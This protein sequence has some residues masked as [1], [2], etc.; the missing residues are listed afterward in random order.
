MV[1]SAAL[2]LG[3]RSTA[4]G[5]QA[6]QR[7]RGSETFGAI[8]RGYREAAGLSQ[9]ALAARSGVSVD[10]ISQWE[11]DLVHRPR[12][13]TASALARALDLNADALDHML[14]ATMPVGPPRPPSQPRRPVRRHLLVVLLTLVALL[15]GVVGAAWW[16]I[17]NRTA[18]GT[19]APVIR[20]SFESGGTEHWGKSGHAQPPVVGSVAHDGRQ[21]LRVDPYSTGDNDLPY[22]S[23]AVSGTS[24]PTVG[25]TVSLYVRLES[26][27]TD[28]EAQVYVQDLSFGWHKSDQIT[29]IEHRWEKL[30]VTVPA[31]VTVNGVGVQFACHPFGSPSVVYVD[32]VAW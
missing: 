9:E 2:R 3:G 27:G 16:T 28:V 7:S 13:S 22:V 14:A 12:R 15:A 19:P 1:G 23:V 8:L 11:R 29:L 32:S 26:A 30:A 24:A 21:S 18:A 5:G 20:Y 17:G 4:G 25:Q 10:T 6:E 31:G